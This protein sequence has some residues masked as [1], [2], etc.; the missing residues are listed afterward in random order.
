M[1][2]QTIQDLA[3]LFRSKTLRDTGL[4]FTGN[5]AGQGIGFLATVIVIRHLGPVRFGLFSTAIAVMG[6]A[7][8]FADMGLGTGFVRYASLYLKEDQRKADILFKVTLYLKLA[9]GLLVLLIGMLIAKP[10]AVF[11]FKAPELIPL[12]QLAFIG[13]LGASLWGYLQAILQAKEWFVKYAWINVFNNSIK[14]FS[15]VY[16]LLTNAISENNAMLV[17][18]LVPFAG[19]FVDGLIV[20]K[21]FLKVKEKPEER[22]AIIIKLI[23]FSKWITLANLCTMLISRVD[24]FM[25]Q[26]LS[27]PY[28]VGI[29]SGASQLATIFP[30]ITSSITTSIL[31]KVSALKDKTQLA[32]FVNT[33]TKLTPYLLI[34]LLITLGIAKPLIK[35]LFGYKYLNSVS[36]FYL[37]VVSFVCGVYVN[38]LSLVAFSLN[39]VRFLTFVI[40]IQLPMSIM[41]NY[42]LIPL[43][44]GMGASISTLIIKTFGNIIICWYIF[45]ILR[46]NDDSKTT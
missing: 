10:L 38:Q 42:Y 17:L 37:L 46:L 35:L 34:L 4:V 27:S 45:K 5:L 22:N 29:Y 12:L 41:L 2:K 33:V 13:S 20:P 11:V 32:E 23:H 31:P 25:L 24:I 21:K 7:S 1:V 28:Q 3:T 6:L 40:Y 8:Q 18:A 16:L 43:Y 15:I 39:K 36:I 30:I 44:G 19:F 9:V 26:S 14:L